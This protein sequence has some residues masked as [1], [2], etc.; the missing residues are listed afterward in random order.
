MILD[1]ILEHKKS[2]VEQVKR[3]TP[4]ETI[5]KDLEKARGPRGFKEAVSKKTPTTKI[6]V[7][8]TGARAPFS[9]YRLRTG[10]R[11]KLTIISGM[12]A[13]RSAGMGVNKKTNPNENRAPPSISPT[14]SMM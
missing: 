8:A 6:L 4:L 11:K 14:L 9:E 13:I 12:F 5:K 2:E 7:A 3:E 10:N 1:E